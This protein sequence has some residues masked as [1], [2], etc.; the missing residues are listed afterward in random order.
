MNFYLIDYENV[1]TNGIKMLLEK[2]LLNQN[3]RI[4]I[5]Y[6][7][8]CKN[9]NLEILQNLNALNIKIFI[10]PVQ[11]GTDNA[12]DFQLSSYLGYM[13]GQNAAD[14]YYIVSNDK[15]YDCLQDYWKTYNVNRVSVSQNNSKEIKNNI[16]SNFTIDDV[17]RYLK[18]YNDDVLIHIAEILNRYNSNINI[19]NQLQKYFRDS[20]K[21][22]KIYRTILPLIQNKEMKIRAKKE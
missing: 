2:K 14:N 12:L 8:K 21:T 18:D 4:F 15:G 19:N 11:T 10:E 16:A 1:N 5:F 13:I 6:S 17:K 9:I 20:E 3:D 7:E 22:S